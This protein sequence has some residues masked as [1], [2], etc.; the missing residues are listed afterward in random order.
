MQLPTRR[1]AMHRLQVPSM[2]WLILLA[3]AGCASSPGFEEERRL[4]QASRACCTQSSDIP[5]PVHLKSGDEMELSSSSPH[6]DFGT[7]LT[8]FVHVALPVGTI[9]HVEVVTPIRTNSIVVGGDGGRYAPLIAIHFRL[10]SGEVVQSSMTAPV[11]VLTGPGGVFSVSRTATVPDNAQSIFVGSD[12]SRF[13]MYSGGC[14]R[15]GGSGRPIMLRE[16]IAYPAGVVTFDFR[17][18]AYG[19]VK[20]YFLG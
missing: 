19:K 7:G 18:V 12:T 17:A 1:S 5:V 11:N 2:F 14:A 9:R 8:P 13:G 16:C 20:L 10:A 15:P 6:R 4:L 3:V